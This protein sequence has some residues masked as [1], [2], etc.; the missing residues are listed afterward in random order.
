MM[1]H[2]ILRT[3]LMITLV[4]GIVVSGAIPGYA[5]IEKP[6]SYLTQ[7]GFDAYRPVE[8]YAFANPMYVSGAGTNLLADGNYYNLIESDYYK[9]HKEAC[10]KDAYDVYQAGYRNWLNA[11]E[12]EGLS[13]ERKQAILD[14]MVFNADGVFKAFA[15]DYANPAKTVYLTVIAETAD[16]VKAIAAADDVTLIYDSEQY[17]CAVI[18]FQGNETLFNRII[19]DP[20]VRFVEPAFGEKQSASVRVLIGKATKT[21]ADARDV[22]RY[23]VGL[24]VSYE[25]RPSW[26]LENA[27]DRFKTSEKGFFISSDLDFDGR[28]TPEDARLALRI[29]VDLMEAPMIDTDV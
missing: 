7:Q 22:L 15:D 5:R 28:V 24:P 16:A 27:A 2:H 13:A 8:D 1:R 29:A 9:A 19:D 25:T 17:P 26:S 21:P 18:R 10:L 12:K 6:G 23:S 4:C 3:H 14:R 20:A 11:P